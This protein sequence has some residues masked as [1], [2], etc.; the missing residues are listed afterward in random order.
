MKY[1]FKEKRPKFFLVMAHIS[2]NCLVFL[3]NTYPPVQGDHWANNIK[4]S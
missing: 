2:G 4:H 1:R 3:S